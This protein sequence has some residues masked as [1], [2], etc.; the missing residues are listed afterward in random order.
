MTFEKDGYKFTYERIPDCCDKCVY[1]QVLKKDKAKQ[2]IISALSEGRI[3]LSILND[4]RDGKVS[5]EKLDDM[6]RHNDIG[7]FKNPTSPEEINKELYKLQ[8][9]SDEDIEDEMG[10]TSEELIGKI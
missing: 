6:I 9:K 8:L 1:K 7:T 3:T 2:Y 10:N 4:F 5:R